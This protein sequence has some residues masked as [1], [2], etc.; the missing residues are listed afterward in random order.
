MGA[1]RRRATHTADIL[2]KALSTIG[3]DAEH[4]PVPHA[5]Y[6]ITMDND[7]IAGAGRLVKQQRLVGHY[8][9]AYAGVLS[10]STALFTFRW[11]EISFTS[12]G[13]RSTQPALNWSFAHGR[14]FE[15]HRSYRG[16]PLS[17]SE[18]ESPRELVLGDWYADLVN[19]PAVNLLSMLTWDVIMFEALGGA[20]ALDGPV[21]YESTGTIDALSHVQ[22]DLGFQGCRPN[23]SLFQNGPLISSLLGFRVHGGR[24]AAVWEY[25]GWGRLDVEKSRDGIR[26]EGES[27][28]VGKVVLDTDNGDLLRAEMLELLTSAVSRADGKLVPMHK[29]RIIR[30]EQVR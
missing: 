27:Y 9:R 1:F 2:T 29:R 10:A 21:D 24:P 19:V 14:T 30:T 13:E 12:Q 22:V 6:V 5:S 15:Y 4:R 25:S 23:H 18:S 11:G 28:F 20:V 17:T 7:Y 8:D 16:E 3:A 26:Q